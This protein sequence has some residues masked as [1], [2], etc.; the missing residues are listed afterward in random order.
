MSAEDT[1]KAQ[2]ES[3]FGVE[4][5]RVQRLENCLDNACAKTWLG[6]IRY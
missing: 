5:R 2:V 3:L 1:L 4:R 6:A